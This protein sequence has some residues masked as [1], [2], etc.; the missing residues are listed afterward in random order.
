MHRKITTVLSV[1]L[2]LVAS[3]SAQSIYE[4]NSSTLPRGGQVINGFEVAK[5]SDFDMFEEIMDLFGI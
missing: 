4:L 1:L 2:I 3:V 5:V